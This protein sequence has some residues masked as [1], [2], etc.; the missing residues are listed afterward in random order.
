[1]RDT[2]DMRNRTFRRALL[3]LAL[4]AGPLAT[5]C[6][7]ALD[8]DRSPLQPVYEAGTPDEGGG[9][10]S[11]AAAET[12]P[13]AAGERPADAATEAAPQDSGMDVEGG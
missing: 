5:A 1:M 12:S 9:A 2:T 13:E 6:E 8:F 7:L 11:D 4:A 10:A 3:A